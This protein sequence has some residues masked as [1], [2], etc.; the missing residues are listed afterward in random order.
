LAEVIPVERVTAGSDYPH[1]DALADPTDFAKHLD[2]FDAEDVRKVMRE[3][4]RGLLD[5]RA[6]N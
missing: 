6:E 3:N 4:L 1:Y 5:Q 2:G